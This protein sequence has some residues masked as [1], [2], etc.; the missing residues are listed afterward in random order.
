MSDALSVSPPPAIPV[1]SGHGRGPRELMRRELTLGDG[2]Q[3]AFAAESIA[4]PTQWSVHHDRHTL[5]VHLDGPMRRL[6]TRIEGVGRLRAPPAAGD[7]WLIPAGR[8]YQGEA[9]GGEIA[10]AELTIDPARYPGL[11][12]SPAGGTDLAARMKHHDPLVHALAVRLA[13]L[14]GESDDLAAMLCDALSQSLCLHLLREHGAGAAPPREPSSPL[15]APQRRRVEDY[16]ASHLDQPIRLAALSALTGL[17]THR[18]LI[19]FRASFGATPIQ[20]VLA[21][22]L[23]RVCMRLRRGDDDITTIAIGS[24]FSSHS[25]LSAVFKRRYGITPSEYRQRG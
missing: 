6:E 17:S 14:S 13:G 3:F 22:R 23:Q 5:I 18:L 4:Q 11:R 25:H 16:I 15:S 21:Q 9:Q 24:G 19:A 12:D 1:V 7:L 8:R 20:Y 2:V 10:Y